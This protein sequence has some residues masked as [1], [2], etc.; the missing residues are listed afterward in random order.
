MTYPPPPWTLKGH[1]FLNLHLLDIEH[2]RPTIPSELAIVPVFPG[3]TIGGVFVASY[4]ADS[5]MPY[6]ELIIVSGLVSYA[7]KI[8]SWISH[9]YVDH[10]DS[11]AGGR[12]IWGLPK[13][14]AQFQWNL[15]KHPSV[16]VKQDDRTLCQLS[17][18]WQLPSL[19]LPF[20]AAPVLSKLDSTP[21]L[22][23]AQGSL[24]LQLVGVSLEVPDTSPLASLKLGQSWLSFYSDRLSVTAGVPSAI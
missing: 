12:E 8:G 9:I 4:S 17:T 19:P 6:N 1:G 3:K 21:L 23:R 7:G 16:Q 18:Q 15:A 5:V 20:I 22:F 2:V 13:E 14:L 11:V 10:P 24:S